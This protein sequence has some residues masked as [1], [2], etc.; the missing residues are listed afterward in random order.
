M[1]RHAAT[2]D[3]ILYMIHNLSPVYGRLRGARLRGA[4]PARLPEAVLREVLY[5][6]EVSTVLECH[7]VYRA[8]LSPDTDLRGARAALASHHP[9]GALARDPAAWHR[10]DVQ[11]H[12]TLDEQSGNA[13]LTAMI[14]RTDRELEILSRPYLSARRADPRTLRLLHAHHRTILA[15][16]EAGQAEQGMQHM[17][18]HRDLLRDQLVAALGRTPG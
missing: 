17:R 11:F 6:F 4:C 14:A 12:R 8:A 1:T 16:I 7:A 2:V 9:A 5:R 10:L 15:C 13:I 18:V 3:A